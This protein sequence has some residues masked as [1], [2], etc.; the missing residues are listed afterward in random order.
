METL[1]KSQYLK[2]LESYERKGTGI[3]NVFE[4]DDLDYLYLF[5]TNEFNSWSAFL[6]RLIK[7]SL[8][9]KSSFLNAIV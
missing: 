7:F 9:K 5:E 3:E 4:N 1:L 8:V 6:V 2:R